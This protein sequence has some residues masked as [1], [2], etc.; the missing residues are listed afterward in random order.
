MLFYRKLLF[1]RTQNQ[2]GELTLSV[3]D[4]A[5]RAWRQRNGIVKYSNSVVSVTFTF[6]I[7]IGIPSLWQYFAYQIRL[8]NPEESYLEVNFDYVAMQ[9]RL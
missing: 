2:Q 8:M 7:G 3:F 5:V 9:I 6:S 1:T 4:P